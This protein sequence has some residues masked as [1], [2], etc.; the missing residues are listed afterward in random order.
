MENEYR[1]DKTKR[2]KFVPAAEKEEQ[3]QQQKTKDVTGQIT[4]TSAYSDVQ[5]K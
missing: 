3:Q 5:N 2:R 4:V 1:A